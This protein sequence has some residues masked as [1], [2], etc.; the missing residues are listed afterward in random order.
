MFR[1][2]GGDGSHP[3]R[4]TGSSASSAQ[5]ERRF[6]YERRR[7][8]LS[9]LYRV[10]RDNLETLYAAVEAGFASAPLPDF[11]RREL[12][13]FLDCG[14]LCRGFALLECENCPERRLIAFSC[15]GRSLCP[16]CFVVAHL[17]DLVGEMPS[18][19]EW[20]GAWRFRS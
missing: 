10:V 1:S 13:G 2:Q 18:L 14:L 19:V 5:E 7:P 20:R 17:V 3:S 4:A 16:L 11:V 6:S 15:K 9:T 12:E 8:E